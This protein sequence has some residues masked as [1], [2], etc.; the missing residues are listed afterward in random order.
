M[1]EQR[2]ET[3]KLEGRRMAKPSHRW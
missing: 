1:G 3:D 2:G